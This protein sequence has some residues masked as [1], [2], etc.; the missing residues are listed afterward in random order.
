MNEFMLIHA[1]AKPYDGGT[2]EEFVQEDYDYWLAG[3]SLTDWPTFV[4]YPLWQKII[5][6][7]FMLLGVLLLLL[8]V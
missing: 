3:Y 4:H 1:M 7:Y 8:W 2:K 6:S 5:N